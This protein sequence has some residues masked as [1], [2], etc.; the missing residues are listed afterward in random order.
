MDFISNF[1]GV[2]FNIIFNFVD[3]LTPVGTLGISIILFTLVIRLL[4][5]PL[6]IK[7]QRTTRGMSK[8]QPELQKIQQKYAGRKDQQSQMAQSQEMQALYKKYNINPFAGCLPLLIQLPLLWAVYAVFRAPSKYI[9]KLHEIYQEIALKIETILPNSADSIAQILKEIPLNATA[10][11]EIDKLEG[12]ATLFDT[13]SNFTTKHWE[14]FLNKIPEVADE[15]SMLL[16]QTV[17]YEYFIFSLVDTPSQ[18]VATG[19]YFAFLIPICAGASTFIFSKISMAQSQPATVNKDPNAP[20]SQTE[21]MMKTLNIIMP[22]M[23]GSFSYTVPYGLS[24]YWIA[25]NLIMMCQQVFVAKIVKKEE[26]ILD[27]QL[28]AEREAALAQQKKKKKKK[29]PQ[30]QNSQN[31]S[32][33]GEGQ[34]KQLKEPSAQLQIE[35]S[36]K[37]NQSEI[38]QQNKKP[39]QKK[40]QAGNKAKQERKQPGKK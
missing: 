29:S 38:K 21:S 27:A 5:T 28:K 9:T 31:K 4:L 7:Q 32:Q 37:E 19:N 22:I 11:A 25:G 24:L 23:M 8:I 3:V 34:K 39:A 35:D 13:I 1:F 26:A 12:A 30:P 2:I 16:Q 6:Q 18:I 10:K 15:I 20:P 36:T 40:Q 14:I 17:D 33:Q